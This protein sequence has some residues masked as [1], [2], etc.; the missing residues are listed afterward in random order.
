MRK[1]ILIWEPRWH[2]RVVLI[3][4][5]K[6]QPGENVIKLTKAREFKG[7]RFIMTG[8]EIS[9][10]PVG[11]NGKI[12][13][14]EVPLA[15]LTQNEA[16]PKRRNQRKQPLGSQELIFSPKVGVDTPQTEIGR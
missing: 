11:S 8:E 1:S 10:C 14:F 7:K 9:S 16:Q 3:A 4:K 2:D 6:V 13:C 15:K 12:P 5:R